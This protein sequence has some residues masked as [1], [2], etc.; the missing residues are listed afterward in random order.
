[1]AEEDPDG[2]LLERHKERMERK[3]RLVDGK[4]AQAQRD[5]G[6]IVV[7]TGNGKAKSSSGFGM[8]ARALGH[9][10]RVGIVQFIKGAIPTGE[11]RA[12]YLWGRLAP[13][14]PAGVRL[15]AVRVQEGPTLYSEYRG[16]P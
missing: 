1:M 14:L 11:A 3:K 16:E 9:G 5:Q 7:V 15:E 6:V 10:M 12:V 4:I 8:V 2:A 13:G